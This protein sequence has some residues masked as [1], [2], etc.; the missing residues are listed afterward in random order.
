MWHLGSMVDYWGGNRCGW[1]P[2]RMFD[3]HGAGEVAA[4]RARR[5]LRIVGATQ[6]V[7]F[8]RKCQR[9]RRQHQAQDAKPENNTQFIMQIAHWPH[10]TAGPPAL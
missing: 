5:T 2:L 6:V 8:M 3:V 7:E 10:H 1:C 9:L 4:D